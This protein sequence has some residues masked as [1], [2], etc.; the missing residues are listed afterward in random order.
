MCQMMCPCKRL[1]HC[2]TCTRCTATSTSEEEEL[3]ACTCQACSTWS[4]VA[5]RHKDHLLSW[6]QSPPHSSRQWRACIELVVL[7]QTNAVKV[8]QCQQLMCHSSRPEVA[9]ESRQMIRC[10]QRSILKGS[11]SLG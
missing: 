9:S 10:M 2:P 8:L 1:Q 6:Q 11:F 7:F 3:V 4:T 5:I